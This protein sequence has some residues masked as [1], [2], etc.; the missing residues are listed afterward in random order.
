MFNSNRQL[1]GFDSLT[2]LLETGNIFVEQR[3]RHG[4]WQTLFR[5]SYNK[6]RAKKAITT[7]NQQ[8]ASLPKLAG[9]P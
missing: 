8:P 6:K 3:D 5:L 4:N 7:D 2:R 1:D 9:T